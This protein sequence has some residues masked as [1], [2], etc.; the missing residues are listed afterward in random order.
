MNIISVSDI[1]LKNPLRTKTQAHSNRFRTI[2]AKNYNADCFVSNHNNISF[3][4]ISF[5]SRLFG[6]KKPDIDFDK[7][8]EDAKDITSYIWD[9]KAGHIVKNPKAEEYTSI[10]DNLNKE[11]KAQFVKTFCQ[12]TGF[13]DLNEVKKKIDKDITDT[14]KLVCRAGEREPL[15][16]GYTSCCSVGKGTALPGSDCDGLFLVIDKMPDFKKLNNGLFGENINQRLVETSGA[17]YP[18]LF[19]IEYLMQ[20]VELADKIFKEIKTPEKI[21]EYKKN[22]ER[23][24]QDFMTA[25]QFN[26]DL[27]KEVENDRTKNMLYLTAMFVEEL[28]AGTV[29]INNLDAKTLRRIKVSSLYKYSNVVRQEGFKNKTKEKWEIRKQTCNNFYNMTPEEQFKLCREI[30]KSSLGIKE[31]TKSDCYKDFD[32]GNI[33]ELVTTITT[34]PVM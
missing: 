23:S 2:S 24:D 19:D 32:M 31:E 25:G 26:I 3:G 21:E 9:M 30:F 20:Y 4:S 28:R 5:L 29:L 13:P 15:F 10:L 1:G 34:F 14:A 27:A 22:L 17:H 7:Y 8:F 16:L 18:E 12:T 33:G 6:T 11:Q